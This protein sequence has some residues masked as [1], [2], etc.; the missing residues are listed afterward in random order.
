MKVGSRFPFFFWG[1]FF[2]VVGSLFYKKIKPYVMSNKITI[3]TLRSL[4]MFW[5]S[6][7]HASFYEHLHSCFKKTNDK[8]YKVLSVMLGRLEAFNGDRLTSPH[9]Q[10][11]IRLEDRHAG[12]SRHRFGFR[13]SPKVTKLLLVCFLICI[14][15]WWHLFFDSGFC[16]RWAYV[17]VLDFPLASCENF[18]HYLLL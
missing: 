16:T 2:L 6:A 14:I 12:M 4:S 13:F 7:F 11:L 5:W 10:L 9:S 8:I 3:T 15:G 1:V 18:G 17:W